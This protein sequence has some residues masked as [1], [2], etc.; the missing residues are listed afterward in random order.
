MTKVCYRCGQPKDIDPEEFGL[1]SKC[2]A[3]VEAIAAE[4]IRQQKSHWWQKPPPTWLRHPLAY[5][6]SA[7]IGA[8]IFE[9]L[10]ILGVIPRP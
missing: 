6:V 8:L 7:M 3:E 4:K 10:V 9:L 2:D 1:C 5:I